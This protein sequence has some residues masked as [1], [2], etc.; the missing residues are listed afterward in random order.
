MYYRQ[1]FR[2][3][4]GALRT[5]TCS[6]FLAEGPLNP[7]YRTS[8]TPPPSRRSA[9]APLP[10]ASLVPWKP[11]PPAS[12]TMA[13]QWQRGNMTQVH[14]TVLMQSSLSLI[15]AHYHHRKPPILGEPSWRL[16]WIDIPIEQ[17]APS[18]V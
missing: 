9:P 3:L 10:A 17:H 1:A 11:P 2:R 16:P 4:P 5:G 7:W 13:T 14:Q 6:G 8:W 12:R 15:A 18:R